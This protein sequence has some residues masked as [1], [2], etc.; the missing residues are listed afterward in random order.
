MK[1]QWLCFSTVVPKWGVAVDARG[2][3]TI[4]VA[5]PAGNGRVLSLDGLSFE[6]VENL[7]QAVSSA[8]IPEQSQP[9]LFMKKRVCRQCRQVFN[10]ND[11]TGEVCEEPGTGGLLYY[12][13]RCAPTHCIE[14]LPP[15]LPAAAG[16]ES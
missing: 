2:L 8:P 13:G 5:H 1:H 16:V 6:D 10:L 12:C 14:P 15:A 11:L 3:I 7:L 4:T 9:E